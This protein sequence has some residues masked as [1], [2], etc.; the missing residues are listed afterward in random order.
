M[1]ASAVVRY[2]LVAML[3]IPV[4]LLF[5]GV[6][7]AVYR[8]EQVADAE[9]ITAIV[10]KVDQQ[11]QEARWNSRS[12]GSRGAP[13]ILYSF[14]LRLEVDGETYTRMLLDTA[15]EPDSIWH[16]DD[17][18]NP[19]IYSPGARMPVL[20]RRDL[21]YAVAPTGGWAVW[22]TPAFLIGFGLFADLPDELLQL[23]IWILVRGYQLILTLNLADSLDRSRQHDSNHD[24]LDDGNGPDH[25]REV[26][27]DAKQQGEQHFLQ[28]RARLLVD[29]LLA[30]SVAPLDG[31]FLK[32]R[33]QL[34]VS[35][36][37]LQRLHIAHGVGP[38]HPELSLLYGPLFS[39]FARPAD[40][41]VK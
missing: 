36:H 6:R 14:T 21:G 38:N 12:T 35:R 1:R 20:L 24:Q 23:E 16:A 31:F 11:V 25:E 26:A 10:E 28:A 34:G 17:V 40:K 33:E 8:L 15:F 7:S 27:A 22:E 4:L 9:E 30:G 19:H 37:R 29:H 3:L 18:V 5:F 2:L 41:P 32:H 39:C 13:S